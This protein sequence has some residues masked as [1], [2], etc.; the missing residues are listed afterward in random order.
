MSAES[1]IST[2][3]AEIQSVCE[4]NLVGVRPISF[5]MYQDL[6]VFLWKV[7][8]DEVKSVYHDLSADD[9]DKLVFDIVLRRSIEQV[10]VTFKINGQEG[11]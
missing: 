4:R 6:A 10:Y 1:V 9:H 2:I 11:E 7:D 5:E 3:A 8:K